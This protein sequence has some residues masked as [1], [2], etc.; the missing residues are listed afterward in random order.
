MVDGNIQ[1]CECQEFEID[2]LLRNE[3]IKKNSTLKTT[4]FY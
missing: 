4:K 1:V 3:K 2:K